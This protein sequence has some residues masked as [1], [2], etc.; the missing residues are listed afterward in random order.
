M[1]ERRRPVLR[2]SEL[3]DYVYCRR[4]WWLR[5]VR[6]LEPADRAPLEAGERAHAAYGARLSWAGRLLALG[7]LLVLLALL[8]LVL[9]G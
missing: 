5:R 3:A 4:S 2:V 7:I 6:G 9:A 1:S 8:G